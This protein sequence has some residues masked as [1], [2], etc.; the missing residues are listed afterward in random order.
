[1]AS[2]C[3]RAAAG[4]AIALA[5]L[6]GAAPAQATF[7]G[8]NGAIAFAFSSGSG[9]RPPLV[10]RRGLSLAGRDLIFC[11]LTDGAPSDGDCAA[12]TFTAPSYSPDGRLIAFDAG[13]RIGLV[14]AD[15]SAWRLLEAVTADDGEPA[16]SPDGRR[17]VFTGSNDRGGTDVYVRSLRGG[18]ARPIVLEAREPAWSSRNEIAYVREGNVYRCRPSGARRRLVTSGVSPDWSP[19]GR[20]LVLVRPAP[21]LT[22][23]ARIGRL[24]VVGADGRGLR[25]ISRRGDLS[26]P[27]WSPDGR[28]VA[29]EGLYLGVQRRR[30]A[31]GHGRLVAETQFGDEGGFVTVSQPAWRPR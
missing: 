11:E 13:G 1:M 9:D 30:L 27:V 8:R 2:I 21:N 20:R 6:A 29:F 10:E 14:R 25:R 5:G 24:H 31:G 12:R 28:W 4:L 7:P 15:G 23:P 18:P 3:R 17:I 22:E 19:G 26:N 16:F